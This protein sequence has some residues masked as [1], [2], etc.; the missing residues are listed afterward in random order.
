MKTYL[1]AYFGNSSKFQGFETEVNASSERE[2][3]EKVFASVMDENYFPQ[4]DGSILDCDGEELADS[5][6]LTISYD[7]GCF[8]AEEIED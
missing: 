7:G 3:V 2:A 5:T 4:E 6:D 1:V 8:S